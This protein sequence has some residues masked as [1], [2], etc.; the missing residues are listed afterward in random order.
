MRLALFLCVLMSPAL[1]DAALQQKSPAIASLETGVICPPPTV[2]EAQAPDTVAGTTHLIDADPPFLSLDNRVP[3]VMGIGFGAKAMAA[4]IDG[5]SNVE[6]V[7][8]HPPMGNDGITS[9]SF[10]TSI[11]GAAPSLTFYQFDHSYEV[12]IG[13]WMLEARREGQVLY[14]ATFEVVRPQLVPELAAACG[15]EDM[16]S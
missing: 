13:T 4:D 7:V 2:G 8:T 15:F 16:L 10:R 14:R 11:N 3:A 12:L 6:M 9:Q 5:L 1:A